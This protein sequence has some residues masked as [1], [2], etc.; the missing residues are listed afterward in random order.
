MQTAVQPP[1]LEVFLNGRRVGRLRK[2]SS[3]ATDFQYHPDWLAW[4]STFPISLSLPLRTARYTG[5]RVLAVFENLLPDPTDLREKIAAETGAAGTDAYS[6]LAAIGRDCIGALQFLP[7][8]DE[9]GAA[10]AT[11]GEEL[12][13]AGLAALLRNLGRFPLG[14]D[15]SGAFRISLAGAQ[16]KTALLK[17]DGLWFRPLGST[18][19]TH[20]LKP[21][22]GRSGGIDLQHSVG[23][24]H[25][26]L[27]VLGYLGLPTARTEILQVED[28]RVL[29]VERFD[30]RWASDGRLLRLPQEDFCQALSVPSHRKYEHHGGPGVGD[31]L[32]LL[33]ASDDPVADRA[34]LLKAVIGFWLLAATDG[35]AKNFSLF[36]YPGGG[37]RLTPLYD[38]LSV[39]P[40]LE[41]RQVLTSR[42]P[43]AMSVG[44][45]A[46]IDRIRPAHFIETAEAAG[47]GRS[48]VQGIF[49]DLQAQGGKAVERA[50]QELAGALPEQEAEAILSGFQTRLKQLETA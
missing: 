7:E 10:G 29:A 38:V 17:K 31:L 2:A 8:G 44:G 15:Q 43:M 28:I 49:D 50:R 42:T 13:E 4:S 18:A 14:L 6:L 20:I 48:I 12:T 19:T 22:M 39:Q 46:K 36:L 23:N 33:R 3:G 30:R 16:E 41:S 9:P 37:F 21:A 11:E 47:L 32:N 45:E 1:A 34:T 5:E 24:E 40:L 35:H 25:F 26:C 27:R